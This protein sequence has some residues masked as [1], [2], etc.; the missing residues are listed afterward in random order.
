M[1]VVDDVFS[2]LEGLTFEWNLLPDVNTG[3]TMGTA[4]NI[5]K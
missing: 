3:K 4:S 2:T 1:S 5:I